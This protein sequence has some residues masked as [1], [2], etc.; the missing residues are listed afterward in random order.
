MMIKAS[1]EKND[2]ITELT[3]S[4]RVQNIIGAAGGTA[5][6]VKFGVPPAVFILQRTLLAGQLA[7]LDSVA[8]V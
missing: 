8:Y 5:L 2:V 4:E 3:I 7:K 1:F 6:G